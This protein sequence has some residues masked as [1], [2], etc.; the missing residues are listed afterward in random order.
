MTS[1]AIAACLMLGQ[2][3][4]AGL[5]G[6]LAGLGRRQT[7]AAANRKLT[8][9][10]AAG[11]SF[12]PWDA[13]AAAPGPIALAWV[14]PD[15][16]TLDL[17]AGGYH[18]V[19]FDSFD[20]ANQTF[21][22]LSDAIIAAGNASGSQPSGG[23]LVLQGGDGTADTRALADRVAMVRPMPM[24]LQGTLMENMTGFDPD[25]IGRAVAVA[26]QLG[27]DRAI[28]RLANGYQTEVGVLFGAPLSS[29]ATKRVG[30]VRALAGEP[31]LLVLNSPAH[32]LDRDGE[33]RLRDCLT[34]MDGKTTVLVLMARDHSTAFSPADLTPIEARDARASVPMSQVT[35]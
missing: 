7:A 32:A 23:S 10:L 34:G 5:V 27:L 28:A 3:A 8:E 21:A 2:R 20:R 4:V 29:G 13:P 9:V 18:V 14:T 11:G 26:E 17:T 19:T 6:I 35:A 33:R 12:V 31:G 24:L 22:A 1:G 30:L 16:Q 15:G 25:K